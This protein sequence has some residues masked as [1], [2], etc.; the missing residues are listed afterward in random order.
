MSNIL[1]ILRREL[2][3]YYTS[4]IGYIFMIVFLVISVG[5]FI[6]A[7]FAFPVADMRPYFSNLP[8]LLCVFIPAVTMRVWSEERKENTWEMLLT[9]PMKAW[10]LVL[11]KFFACLVFFVITLAAT[12][13]LPLMLA[14]LGNPD[15]GAVFSAYLGAVLLGAFFLSIGIFFSG[16]FKDQIVAFVVTLAVCFILFLLGLTPI[17]GYIDG[18]FPGLGSLLAQLVGIIDHYT[19]FIR[20]VV[21]IADILYFAAWTAIFLFLNIKFIDGRNRPGTR[22]AFGTAVVLS[23]AI[24]FLFNWLISGQSL[25]RFDLTEDKIY[26]VSES[27]RRILSRID[28]PVQIKLYITPKDKMPTGLTQLERDVTDKLEEIGMASDGNVEHSTVHLEVANVLATSD[29]TQEDEEGEEEAIEKRMLD[30]GIQ[31]FSVRAYGEDAEVTSKLI[32]SSI[33]VGYK[34]KP[35]EII[36]QVM[37]EN[38]QEMEYRLVSTI[39][40][41]TLEE[42]PVVALVA[43]KEA[44]QIDPQ[45][46]RM[47]EQVG[48][49][50]PTSEDPYV[51]LERILRY[52]K[53][54]VHRVDLTQDSPLPEDYDALVVIN[55][56][57]LNERQRWEINRAVVSGKSVILAVQNYEWDYRTTQDGIVVTRRDEQPGINELLENYG[58]GIDPDI[59]M[60]NNHVA[61]TIR[62]S[63]NP[64]AGL[65]GGGQTVN[66]PMHI[67]VSNNSMDEETSITNRL[68]TIFYLWGSALN[69]DEDELKQHGLESRTIM[70]TSENAWQVSTSAPMG[71]NTFNPPDSGQKKYPLMAM[72]SGQFPDAYQDKPRPAWPPPAPPPGQQFA[73]P[74]PP[75]EEGEAPPITPAPGKLILLGSSEMFRRNFLRAGNLD[76]FLNS[77]DAVTLGDDLVNVRGRKPIDRTVDKPS[78]GVRRLW[79]FVN[80]ALANLIIAGIGISSAYLRRRSRNAYTM[81]FVGEGAE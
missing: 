49:P 75:P 32:Y 41:L 2:G 25:G 21:E 1:T 72:V 12:S 19:A 28:T 53:Y 13:T 36:P 77:V 37:P 11:G 31:P 35:E 55:P 18:T 43:P 45:M 5:L 44:V 48:Q 65:F 15:G 74:P 33:G 64:L 67:L 54:R 61:M 47:L 81:S 70:T 38:L 8:I 71:M 17:A 63:A 58:L 6:M 59:L 34:D 42:M 27:S 80:Y 26:T 40:K 69:I 46:R 23:L 50:V 66:L 73:S 10:E 22:T 20:G 4:P 79:K 39:H 51:L 29:D 9:F 14:V 3:A 62:S 52:E 68:S 56:R 78:A 30:K 7:F 57:N 24:G 16:F 60:D 76:L